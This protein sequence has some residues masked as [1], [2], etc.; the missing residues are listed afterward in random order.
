M[1]LK[2]LKMMIRDLDEGLQTISAFRTLLSSCSTKRQNK[3][4]SFS[5]HITRQTK[6][7]PQ[8]KIRGAYETNFRISYQKGKNFLVG[9]IKKDLFKKICTILLCKKFRLIF[10]RNDWV[11][12]DLMALDHFDFFS[13]HSL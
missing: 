9:K 5:R 11:N 7:R 13:C 3:E 2:N 1:S 4:C 10:L 8:K 12:L 6:N